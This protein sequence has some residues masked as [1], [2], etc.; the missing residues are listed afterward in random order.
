MFYRLFG[1]GITDPNGIDMVAGLRYW[2]IGYRSNDVQFLGIFMDAQSLVLA[3]H[4]GWVGILIDSTRLLAA[5]LD[6]FGVLL[7]DWKFYCFAH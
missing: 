5:C 6:N 4:V 3:D 7:R 1:Y 2:K